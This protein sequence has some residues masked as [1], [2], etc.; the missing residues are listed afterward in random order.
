MIREA[1]AALVEGRSLTEVEVAGPLPEAQASAWEAGE[2]MVI[3][4]T[5]SHPGRRG[6]A[7]APPRADLKVGPYE[8]CFP[9][10]P[11]LLGARARPSDGEGEGMS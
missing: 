5:T 8:V 10:R 6:E 2:L 9:L 7:S 4:R 1:I 11:V 3:E